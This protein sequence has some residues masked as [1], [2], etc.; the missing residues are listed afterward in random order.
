MASS[1][2]CCRSWSYSEGVAFMPIEKQNHP[3]LL[4]ATTTNSVQSSQVAIIGANNYF[5]VRID[6]SSPMKALIG[7][8]SSCYSFHTSVC[9]QRALLSLLSLYFPCFLNPG[10]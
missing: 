3:K 6:T 5:M 4:F 8:G 10:L 2:R 9:G 1:A 7:T